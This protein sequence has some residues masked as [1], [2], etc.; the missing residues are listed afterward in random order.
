[1]DRALV[2]Q[3]N[4]CKVASGHK[5]DSN[6]IKNEQIAIS[7][8]STPTKGLCSATC[9][10]TVFTYCAMELWAPCLRRSKQLAAVK[11][12][13]WQS[14]RISRPTKMINMVTRYFGQSRPLFNLFLSFQANTT[15]IT[16][17]ICEKC[18]SSIQCWDLNPRPS[19]HES[20]PITTRLGSRPE[21]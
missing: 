12:G 4:I 11:C 2:F 5:Y 16:T 17:N 10:A 3:K 20:P 15:I 19:G 6:D 21:C 14:G 13:K 18:P 7:T 8:S 1:M 9:I